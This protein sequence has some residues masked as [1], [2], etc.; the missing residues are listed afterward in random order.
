MQSKIE[1]LLKKMIAAGTLSHATIFVGGESAVRIETALEIASQILKTTTEAVSHHPDLRVIAR[2]YDEKNERMR[3][4]IRVEDIRN[5]LRFAQESS[6][7]GG[8]KVIIISEAERM[9]EEAYASLLKTLE[10]PGAQTF[11][12]LLYQTPDSIP[13]TIR[14]RSQTFV[15]VASNLQHF[16][17]EQAE[18]FKVLQ[19]DLSTRFQVIEPWLEAAKD[20][21]GVDELVKHLELW[22]GALVP[23]TL[24][25]E[26]AATGRS[27]SDLAQI[28]DHIR[29][30]IKALRQNAHPKLTLEALLVKFGD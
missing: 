13:V 5:M 6:F 23:S 2:E 14:S 12:F 4:D 30:T 8:A 10:E 25:T 19:S 16:K 24:Q 26:W 20:E 18:V 29:A 3:R 17:S 21:G 1:N 28:Q 15:F 22:Q 27:W 7:Q 9:N 11:F